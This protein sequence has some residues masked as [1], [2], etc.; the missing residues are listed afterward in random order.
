MVHVPK[1]AV[2][3]DYLSET[4]ENDIGDSGKFPIMKGETKTQ[5]M[6]Q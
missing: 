5:A 4:R 1:T 3:E 2:H 6:Y